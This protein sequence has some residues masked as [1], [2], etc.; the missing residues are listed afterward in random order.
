MKSLQEPG[1]RTGSAPVGGRRAA[2]SGRIS[3][4]GIKIKLQLAFAAVSTM[5]VVAAAVAITSFSAAERGVASVAHVEVP[6][7][8]DALRLSAMSGEISAAAAR[9]VSAKSADEQKAIANAI[10]DRFRALTAM[11]ER[12]RHGRS[13]AAFGAVETAAQRLDG[14]LKALAAVI[15]ERSL[16]RASLEAKLDALQKTHARIADK[17]API[18][19]DSYFD[20]VTTAEDVGKTADK[21][22]KSLVND[23]LQVMQALVEIGAETNLVTGLLTA[24]TLTSSP[25]ILALLEDRFTSSVRRAQ[26]QFAKLPKGAKFDNLRERLAALVKLADFKARAA[27]GAANGASNES[28]TARLQNVFRAHESL[29]G[30]LIT[31]IDDL[32][33]DLV[34]QSDD[35]IKR[36]SKV[37]KELV[38][39]QIA[40]LRNALEIAAQTHLVASLISE[41][42]FAREAAMLVPFQDRFKASSDT[43]IKVSKSL[44][45]PE[46]KKTIAE[47]LA[48]GQGSESV[49]A[50]R[51]KELTAVERA[52]RAIEENAKIQRELDQAV[53]VLV[54][55]TDERM[56]RGIG[57]LIGNL[58]GN[59]TLL[60]IV[61][62]LSLIASGAIAWLYVQRNLIRRLGTI[63]DAMR[64]LSAGTT[65]LEVPAAKDGDE[66]GEMARA[67][68]VFRD[69]ALEN[70]RLEREA[71]EQRR[72]S[73]EQAARVAQEERARSQEQTQVVRALN[74][75]LGKLSE[76][77]LT[78]RLSD[79]FPD[80]YREIRDE[81]NS[82]ASRLRE[83][84]QALSE[85]TREVSH[86]SSEISASTTDL[87]QRTEEQAANLEETSAS[88]EQISQIV[89]RTADNARQATHSA[90]N[91]FDI[92][93]RNGQVVSEAVQAMAR[94][95]ESSRQISDIIGV[96]DEIARQTNL[97]ALNAAVEAARAG[98]AGRGF[99]VVASEV[100]SLAQRS[101]EAA[102]HIKQLI[103][104]SN[105][106]VR[107][108]VD[109]VKT[110]GTALSEIVGA[111][112]GVS[113]IVCE[114]AAASA[115]QATGLEQ[116]SQAVSQ[117]DGM[118]QQNSALV[119]EN[120]ATA[121][122]LDQQARAMDRQVAFF[123]LAEEKEEKTS[124]R[125]S[126]N[127]VP[128]RAR[129]R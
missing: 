66:L 109:L 64:C 110:A 38:A 55:E 49:F 62:V 47:L 57:G 90:R 116:V 14:N 69:R 51:A 16:L 31:L 20:V 1:V 76:G 91:A 84:L 100:R 96:I 46:V 124:R 52:D 11:L 50:L 63:G 120:A 53:S 30:I 101:S 39:N 92:A 27:N 33:F 129:A 59:R 113:D 5:T 115:D 24:G 60:I 54:N 99:A 42:S 126:G 82:T 72:S 119:E 25:S 107:D 12:L 15:A 34:M 103:T 56:Q 44:D 123:R 48:F 3:R 75:G 8:T 37:I 87:S 127:V 6:L 121:K 79:A 43:L 23:G 105:N 36:S 17:L 19:D 111:I 61:A 7:M 71:A 67:V 86:A 102:K 108:G 74:E 22:V 125:P 98:E 18:V 28:E 89:K 118:T 73:A 94:I 117:M 83:T 10:Q 95:E 35:A 29:T 104:N 106:Q 88:L 68:L 26:R 78:I 97:L 13:S 93:G 81:F 21:I 40:G 2:P 65:E 70:D 32:N 58:D 9:F 85:A 80:A 41:A 122:M 45:S 114:I 128:H 77:D 112:K 4:L